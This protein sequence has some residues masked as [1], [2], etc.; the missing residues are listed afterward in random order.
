MVHVAAVA[1]YLAVMAA[2]GPDPDRLRPVP[3][4]VAYAVPAVLALAGLRGRVP[5][6]LAA[7][8][9][10]GVLAVFPF[11]VHSFVLAP[12][13]VVYAVAFGRLNTPRHGRG[14]ALAAVACPLLLVAAFLVLL[15]QDHPACYEE[16]ETGEVV[17]DR[18]P[19]DITSRSIGPDS[20]VVV[21]GCT[22]DTVVW[23][24]AAASLA[25]SGAGVA[26]GLLSVP[27]TTQDSRR[28]H[29][30]RQGTS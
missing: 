16:L 25:L 3:I 18:D 1:A 20:D 15:V 13:A 11:S 28:E 22:S 27:K 4:A 29:P 19:G 17:V 9:A 2:S 7:A 21:A 30:H 6:L 8:I 26:T 5:L 14:A 12:A 23:W 24:E 10:A